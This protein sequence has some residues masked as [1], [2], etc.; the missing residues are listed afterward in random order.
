MRTQIQYRSV[1]HWNRLANVLQTNVRRRRLT[2]F[3]SI[4]ETMLDAGFLEAAR[5]VLAELEN[6][7]VAD[8]F[9]T[10]LRARFLH[11]RGG[12]CARLGLRGEARAIFAQ[13]GILG[14]QVPDRQITATAELNLQIKLSILMN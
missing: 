14:E 7:V 13:L 10:K 11:V 9:P 12:I 3:L 4:I 8:T 2:C 1:L 6:R 5:N